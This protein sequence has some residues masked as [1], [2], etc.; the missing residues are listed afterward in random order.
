MCW[1]RRGLWELSVASIS[2]WHTAAMLRRRVVA[3]LVIATATVSSSGCSDDTRSGR[4]GR[5]RPRERGVVIGPLCDLLPWSGGGGN[6]TRVAAP[7]PITQKRNQTYSTSG[8]LSSAR[9][10]V[11]K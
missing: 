1:R 7:L 6:R 5:S 4:L 9:S 3:A 11:T 2:R 8:W 10:R